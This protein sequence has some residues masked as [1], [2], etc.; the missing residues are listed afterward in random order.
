[1]SNLLSVLGRRRTLH[2]HLLLHWLLRGRLLL[3]QWLLLHLRRQLLKLLL[4]NGLLRHRNRCLR[5]VLHWSL[6]LRDWLLKTVHLSGGGLDVLRLLLLKR[7]L[8]CWDRGCRLLSLRAT[9]TLRGDTMQ[10]SGSQFTTCLE[11]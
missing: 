9:L 5:N 7:L 3:L 10:N 4:R 6:L 1:M 8:L 2:W 11:N